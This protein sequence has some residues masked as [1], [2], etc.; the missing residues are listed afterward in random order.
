VRVLDRRKDQ[1][2]FDG[3]DPIADADLERSAVE[4]GRQ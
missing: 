4:V 2:L 1:T 3:I